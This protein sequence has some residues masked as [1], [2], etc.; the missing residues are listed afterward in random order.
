MPAQCIAG[1]A[2]PLSF[3]ARLTNN[4]LLLLD[5]RPTRKRKCRALPTAAAKSTSAQSRSIGHIE[6]SRLARANCTARN[7][8]LVR[9]IAHSIKLLKHPAHS[10]K[11]L[12]RPAHNIKLLKRP[13]RSIS[14][15]SLQVL[16]TRM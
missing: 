4:R 7:T 1:K 14:L 8:N 13:A 3:G 12:K 2:E 9:R 6:R 5:M 11:L 16:C 15:L 10:I